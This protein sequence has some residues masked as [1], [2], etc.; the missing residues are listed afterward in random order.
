MSAIIAM[1]RYELRMLAR[2]RAAWITAA[3]LGVTF[4]MAALT[5]VR[6]TRFQADTLAGA[7]AEETTRLQA[8][9]SAAAAIAAGA[10]PAPRQWWNNPAD[11]RGF[12]YYQLATYAT[13]PPAPLAAL[14]VGQSDLLPFY[15]RMNATAQTN[16]L[17]A[18]EADNPRRLL[19][20]RFDLAFAAIVVLPLALLALC[21]DV[22]GADRRD[23][24]HALLLTHGAT[25]RRLAVVRLALRFGLCASAAI[26]ATLAVFV[27]SG[28]AQP[29]A[30]ALAPLAGWL[31]VATA[32]S[33]FW[34][35][36]IVLVVSRARAWP[37]ASLTLLSVWLVLVVIL[38]WVLNLAA[39]T[40][41]PL[42]SRVDYILAMRTANDE[43]ENEPRRHALLARFLHDH[44]ELAPADARV[45]TMHYTAANVAAREEVERRLA[46]VHRRFEEQLARQQAL[47]DTWQW[48]SPAVLTQQA[49]NELAGSGWFRHRWFLGLVNDYI[50]ELRDFFNPRVLS[51]Q[52]RFT[53]FD[54]WPRF[55]WIEPDTS[56]QDRRLRFA[57]LGILVPALAIGALGLR[58]FE[59]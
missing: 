19:L 31:A 2:D 43:V 34:I 57:L 16:A 35:A 33:L 21:H 36:V 55:R 58:R 44:P 6:W 20:G 17:T 48:L 27:L 53:E 52:F 37:G 3:L 4:G 39:N 51:G 47:I 42:P 9:R 13:K 50:G 30:S 28:S 24:R 45:D 56:E 7:R 14:T 11:V 5:G 1:L 10:R 46:P 49:F 8:S 38:P 25:P 15:F 59:S 22:V 40:S 54:A 23:G 26:A 32:Y 12:A 29:L 41:H 18:Y